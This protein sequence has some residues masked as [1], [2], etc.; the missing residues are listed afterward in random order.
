M[1]SWA[2]PNLPGLQGKGHQLSLRDIH[3][4]QSRPVHAG[5]IATIYACG[6]TPY[7]ATHLGHAATYITLDLASRVL[8]DA[9]HQVRYVQNVTDIDDP[10][11]ERAARDGV[12][13]RELATSEIGLFHTD[14]AALR[15]LP[16]DHYVSVVESMPRQVATIQGLVRKGVTYRV[17][18]PD[19]ANPGDEDVYLDLSTQPTFGSESGWS[20]EQMLEVFADRG[21]DPDRVGKRDALDPLLW[22]VE[23]A[24]EPAWEAGTLGR[25]RPGWHVECTTI[26]LDFLGMGFDLQGGGTDLIFP[27]HEMSAVQAVAL[28]DD[29]PFAHN[30]VHQAMV[31]YDG[32]KMSKSKGNLVRVSELRARGVDPMAIRLVLLA[33]HYRTPWE[34]TEDLLTAALDRWD[35]WREALAGRGDDG[36]D[37][38]IDGVRAALA[39]DLDSAAALQLV[40]G[41]AAGAPDGTASPRVADA[42]DALLGIRA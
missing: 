11:L 35:R 42:L 2:A 38:L 12:D 4:H 30:Y 18:T 27:H 26:A 31:G 17:P 40:D 20:R 10:L 34:Y 7:D 19:A 13:W 15:V 36:A 1:A 28:T 21:G 24:G 22:R 5:E 8:R 3:T 41:W 37:E 16:P 39:D 33:Q 23:R 29:P 25:G 14:M 6:I 9:G 32:E